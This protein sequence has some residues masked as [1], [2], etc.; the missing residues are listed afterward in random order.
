MKINEKQYQKC[1]GDS[2]FVYYDNTYT[3]I[4]LNKQKIE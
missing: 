1:M 3:C 4:G 2:H